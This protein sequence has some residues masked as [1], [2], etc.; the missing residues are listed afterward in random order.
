MNFLDN[1]DSKDNFSGFRKIS[2]LF[3]S[4]DEF[5]KI[6][7]AAVFLRFK[8]GETI[9]KQ[10]HAPTHIAYLQSGIVK[11]NFQS[12]ENEKNT[13]LTLVSAPKILGG[14]NLFYKD[15]NLFSI[16]AVEDC[17]IFLIEASA[18]YELL[19]E[20]GN[21]AVAL[22]QMASEMFKKSILNFISVA[23]K[24][25]EARIADVF[26]YLAEEIYFGTAFKLSLTRKEIAEFACCS[27]ENIIMTLSKWQQEG[28]VSFSGKNLEITNIEKLRYISKV[29]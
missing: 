29:G 1:K 15:N 13:I 27:V 22:F 24:Q 5:R 17:E 4:D 9:L 2:T 26:I 6:E 28:I 25:K 23:N 10:G 21:Y 18:L 3:I 12:P 11:F 16:V 8:K 14:A 20:N 19:K 7:K